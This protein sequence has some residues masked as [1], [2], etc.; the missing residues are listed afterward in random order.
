MCGT[1]F[2]LYY[3]ADMPSAKAAQYQTFCKKLQRPAYCSKAKVAYWRTYRS[4]YYAKKS[5]TVLKS[6]TVNCNVPLLDPKTFRRT[7]D[8]PKDCTSDY[9]MVNGVYC[10]K[11]SHLKTKTATDVVALL[12]MC[13]T[14]CMIDPKQGAR[15]PRRSRAPHTRK[16][17][18]ASL[19]RVPRHATQCAAWCHHKSL[20][21]S[22]AA[23]SN[24]AAPTSNAASATSTPRSEP[25]KCACIPPIASSTPVFYACPRAHDLYDLRHRRYLDECLQV[26]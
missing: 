4:G 1:T 19:T 3:H 21:S 9:K 2:T 16:R 14:P 18:G 20:P 11:S 26:R 22:H 8:N 24:T 25:T 23:A 13:T 17:P 12:D 6:G 15:H 5:G 7:Y 10:F